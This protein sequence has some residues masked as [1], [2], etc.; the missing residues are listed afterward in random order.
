MKVITFSEVM[1]RLA[2]PQNQRFSQAV[3]FEATFGGGE[4]NVA[5]SLANYGIPVEF[6]SKIPKNDI[7]ESCLMTLRKYNVG[8]NQI[9]RGGER[10][11]ILFSTNN[12]SIKNDL[13]NSSV[14]Y[15]L[16]PF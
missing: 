6:V 10:L 7:G 1:L 8:T 3:N 16:N 14:E 4:A 9:L 15:F 12:E 2:T 5:V 11:G 13:R